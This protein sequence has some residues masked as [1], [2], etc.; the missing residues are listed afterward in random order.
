MATVTDYLTT[1]RESL[2][3]VALERKTEPS[4]ILRLTLQAN[5]GTF[6]L[7]VAGYVNA[8]NLKAPMTS[9]IVLRVPA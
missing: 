3:E 4:V 7:P 8:C 9:G 2:A 1:G 5:G 6:P